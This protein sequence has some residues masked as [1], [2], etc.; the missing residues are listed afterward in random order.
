METK[1]ISLFNSIISDIFSKKMLTNIIQ[2][3]PKIVEPPLKINQYTTILNIGDMQNEKMLIFTLNKETLEKITENYLK[4]NNIQEEKPFY[5][6]FQAIVQYILIEL[7]SKMFKDISIFKKKEFSIRSFETAE[8][9]G[10][11]CISNDIVY[12]KIILQNIGTLEVYFIN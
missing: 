4:K 10:I 12:F 3:R 9:D 5:F 6:A 2:E 1:D 8:T 11:Y 7:I